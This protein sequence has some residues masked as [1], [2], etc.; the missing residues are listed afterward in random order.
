MPTINETKAFFDSAASGLARENLVNKWSVISDLLG[1]M[2]PET[3]VLECGAGTGLYT[4]PMLASGYH[5]T[6]IDLS[7]GSLN[8]LQVSVEQ[9]SDLDSKRLQIVCGD[10][11]SAATSLSESYDV[12][13][14]F[15]VLHHFPNRDYIR[16]AVRKAFD[17]LEP[18]GRIVAFEPNGACPLW[19]LQYRVFE[20][21]ESWDNERNLLL[22]K[23]RFLDEIFADLPDSSATL[24]YRYMI[25][26]SV[27][28][29]WPALGKVDRPLCKFAPLN[30]LAVNLSFVIEKL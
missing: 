1:P 25:P 5:V 22:I 11:L 24:D 3:R 13:T 10:F 30:R 7:Q 27:V 17:L 18:G 12:V 19:W 20:S 9:R 8:Q 29:R 6:S 2:G 16:D 4:L 26:G 28:N 15:K 21:K 14:F 23:K